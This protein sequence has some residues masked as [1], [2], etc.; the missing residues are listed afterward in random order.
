[1][2][3][4]SGLVLGAKSQGRLEIGSCWGFLITSL[5]DTWMG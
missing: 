5:E 3:S 2:A 1:M 4:M